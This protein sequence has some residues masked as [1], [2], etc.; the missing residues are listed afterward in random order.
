MNSN[1]SLLKYTMTYGLYLGVAFSFV[2]FILH[3]AGKVHF[4]GDQMAMFNSFLLTMG[5]LL[6]GRRYRDQIHEGVFLYRSAF[7]LG[8]LMVVF[9]AIIYSFFNYWYYLVIEPHGIQLFIDQM[10][11]AYT[12]NTNFS[13]DQINALMD[14]YRKSLTPGAMAFTI[15]FMQLIAGLIISA[16]AALVIRTPQRLNNN[17]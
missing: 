5:L 4:P 17:K 6:F 9:S 16:F 8:F 15:L 10:Q 11:L 2:V 7:R 3:W 14:L 1:N 12:Q 13:E